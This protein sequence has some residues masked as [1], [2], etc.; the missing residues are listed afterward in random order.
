MSYIV[1][2]TEFIIYLLYSFLVGYVFLDFIPVGKKPTINVPNRTIY[3]AILGIIVLGLFPVF[4]IIFYFQNA[5]E[6]K[7]AFYSVFV[8]TEIG[9]AWIISSLF[10][11]MLA[12]NIYSN[13]KK[14]LNAF[15]LFLMILCIG[16]AGH[17]TSIDFWIGFIFQSSHILMVSIWSG[18][19]ILIAWFSTN[20]DNY[21][22]FLK[23]FT[24]LAISCIAIIFVSGFLLM[25]QVV[26][27]E[28][29]TNA[30][31]LP[32]GQMLLL[33]HLSIIP[34][35]FFAFI[36][37]FLLKKSTDHSND[38]LIIKW[39]R[40]E[41][42]ILTF[43]FFFTGMMSTKSPPHDINFTINTEGPSK[44]IEF[45]MGIDIITPLRLSFSFSIEGI[46][47]ICMSALFLL[48]IFISLIKKI[49]I[50]LPIIFSL[51]FVLTMYLGLMNS[52][53]S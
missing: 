45:I 11:S 23:W 51:C 24:P 13:G 50:I 27:L 12:I 21:H 3:W 30:W 4:Q 19:L 25:V 35:L 31:I 1:P 48:L 26:K 39:L 20:T 28:D 52:I 46:I 38:D 42:I 47:L 18:I 5:V 6:F 16:Y 22:N 49:K 32:Y 41:S 40:A 10:A 17:I 36:N 43:V 37:A 8:K 44:W 14:F 9:K 15:W 53:S 2:I 29:Y 33:K 34:V 7:L